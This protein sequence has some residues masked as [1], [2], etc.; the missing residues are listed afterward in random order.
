MLKIVILSFCLLSVVSTSELA[1]NGSASTA[2][3]NFGEASVN[4]NNRPDSNIIDNLSE[5]NSNVLSV[6]TDDTINGPVSNMMENLSQHTS[7]VTSEL[8]SQLS[9]KMQR[10]TKT[11]VGN[12]EVV[13]SSALKQ[14]SQPIENFENTINASQCQPLVTL[15]ELQ[16][17]IN[18]DLNECTQ[19]LSDLLTTFQ[20]DAS[21][22]ESLLEQNIKNI[23][24]LPQQCESVD[25]G[26][27]FGSHVS[28]Y[29]DKI[30][31]INKQIA[32]ILNTA[33]MTLVH[34]RQLAEQAVKEGRSC[35]DN[36]VAIT[37]E[38][39]DKMLASC[40]LSVN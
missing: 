25:S 9:A 13:V 5:H 39:L 24:A 34:T 32:A 29:V 31:E 27:G 40:Q 1:E 2:V 33:S 8:L 22:F 16:K 20:N 7:S 17:R 6:S 14:L 4:I 21:D 19:N 28:C 37:V 11:L 15:E 10:T 12:I 30:S 36:V 38:S 23:I 3:E 35:A 26:S 18:S